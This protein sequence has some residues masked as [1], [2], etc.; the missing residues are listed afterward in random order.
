MNKVKIPYETAKTIK[1]HRED[2]GLQYSNEKIVETVYFSSNQGN[3]WVKKLRKIDL[4][5]LVKALYEG[6]EVDMDDFRKELLEI[7]RN[8]KAEEIMLDKVIDLFEN[9]F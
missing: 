9:N 1:M 7:I 3:V 4:E 5:T 2:E 8:E 6:Y